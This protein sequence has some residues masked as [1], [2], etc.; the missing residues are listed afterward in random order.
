MSSKLDVALIQL[1]VGTDKVANI[2]HAK[3]EVIKAADGG[4]KIGESST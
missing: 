1:L 4:A 2:K 3:E